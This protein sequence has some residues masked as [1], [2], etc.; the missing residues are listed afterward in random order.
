MRSPATTSKASRERS[1]CCAICNAVN[2]LGWGAY[3]ADH[4]DAN[5]QY[6]INFRYSHA[7]ETADRLTFFRMMAGQVANRAGAIATFMAKPFATRTGSGAHLH[8]H[9]ADAETGRNLFLDKADPRGLGLSRLAYQFIGGVLE[10]AP[11]LCAVTSPTV[12]CYKR[13]LMG[14]ALT[15]SSS[16]YTWTPAFISYGD[17]NR[18]QM[19]RV[20]EEGHIEDRSISSAFNPYLGMAAYLAAGLDGI[21][22]GS[23]AASQTWETSTP[24][25]LKPWPGAACAPFLRAF[26]SHWR[27]SSAMRSCAKAWARLPTNSAGSNAPSG[28]STTPRS[29]RGK[30]IVTLP[31]Y[32]PLSGPC[33]PGIEESQV[34]LMEELRAK[35]VIVGA[36]A[37]GSA[38]AYH[39]ARR[40]E[41]VMLIEQF[42]LGHNRGSSHGAARITRHSYADANYAR[43]MPAAFRAWRE[44][45][46]DAGEPIYVRTGGVSF[47][48][49]GVDYAARVAANLR[50]LE[51]PHWHGSG[52]DWNDRHRVFT[53]PDEYEVVFEPDAG[54]VKA[55]R[56]VALEIELAQRHGGAKTQ[57]M[58]STAVERIDLDGP[59][60]VVVT[61][62][63]RI[64]AERLIVAAG[65]WAARLLPGLAVPLRVTRQQVLYVRAGDSAPY[66][67]GR[68]PVFIYKGHD[69]DDAYY[70]LP[71]I[72]ETG[73]KV[74]RHG[75]PEF[76]PDVDDHTVA[77]A[78]IALVRRFLQAH[79][80]GL[81]AAPIDATETCLYTVAP[82]ERFLVDFLPGRDDVV[83]ASPCSGH[84]FKFS[85]LIGRVL[86]DL[87]TSGATNLDIGPWKI[88]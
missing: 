52:R 65:G 82:D 35:H 29:D 32:R 76:D 15:G 9:L 63:A 57:V 42:A 75:G 61:G 25:I 49:R 48:P 16:G 68:F 18:T 34:I 21:G 4:E 3:Q 47:A 10:H 43:L 13:L 69:E 26:P 64:V 45:E 78:Y 79:I 53:L 27:S 86:A 8:Y 1:A 30:S 11:A 71:E 39:L 67:V 23:T 41:P 55:A 81:A 66:R 28:A 33:P 77:A 14:P 2:E 54:L 20:P 46:A 37:M 50:E 36:G 31:R 44:L 12:N 24:P 22:A 72:L 87:A 40:G 73:V 88:S 58:P 6:E 80:P 17:N 56:S 5:F 38:A 60:P 83:I 62:R 74:A 19:L 85:C 51:V 84:G 59:R 70:G 7:L